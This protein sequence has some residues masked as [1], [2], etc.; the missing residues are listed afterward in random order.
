MD[1]EKTLDQEIRTFIKEVDAC[2]PSEE[3]ELANVQ[4]EEQRKLY[5]AMSAN[6]SATLPS[7]IQFKDQSIPTT[8][9]REPLTSDDIND[10]LPDFSASEAEIGIRTYSSTTDGVTAADTVIVYLHGGGFIL[11][12]LNSHH[13]VCAELCQQTGYQVMSVDYRLAPEHHHPAAYNDA[14]AAT[15]YATNNYARVLLCGDSAGANLCA[16]VCSNHA[17]LA[18]RVTAQVLIYP[19]L[20]GSFS[21]KSYYEH[22]EAPQ[23]S[24]DDVI[25]YS[26]IR[27]SEKYKVQVSRFAECNTKD[28]IRM[29]AGLDSYDQSYFQTLYPLFAL[30][31]N[32]NFHAPTTT[33]FAAQCDPLHDDSTDYCRAINAGNV[34]G[35]GASCVSEAG[36]VHGYLRAR[37]R[38]NRAGSSFNAIVKALSI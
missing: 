22:A 29:L 34:A 14:V 33:C 24:R 17:A 9:N 4:I 25:F 38:S 12:D 16:A 36:L 19:A 32:N 5:N 13:D 2:Y 23:L 18:S 26:A 1:Y 11:G 20:N 37:H 7:D 3:D 27:V 10:P 6:L 31:A 28:A 21:E 30:L 35:N 15:A 8:V